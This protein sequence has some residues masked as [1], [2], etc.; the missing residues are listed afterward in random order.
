MTAPARRQRYRPSEV[1]KHPS[2]SRAAKTRKHRLAQGVPVMIAAGRVQ[3]HVH[4]LLDAGF[5]YYSIAAAAGC[6]E[7]TI[8]AIHAGQRSRVQVDI[9]SRI[10]RVDHVPTPAQAGTRVAS[11]GAHRRI[12]ALRAAGWPTA[13]LASR[14]GVGV[15]T[16]ERVGRPGC[17]TVSYSTW[18][19]V[20]DVYDMLSACPGPSDR[21]RNRVSGTARLPMEWEGYDID[22][23]RVTPPS[24]RRSGRPVI[25]PE[26]TQRRREQVL[27]LT[28]RGLSAQDIAA[29]LRIHPRQ[30][31][32]DRREAAR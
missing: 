18:R 26:A 27:E 20:R 28:R 14:S 31:D 9:A 22:D 11:I 7:P 5:T 21:A 16:L 13:E 10:L 29:Q 12:L 32:R 24:A 8:H 1:A 15:S 30:V 2:K 4:W 3:T 17:Q 6:P 19:A 25:D 23:P